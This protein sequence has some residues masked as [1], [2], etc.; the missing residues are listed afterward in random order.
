[1]RAAYKNTQRFALHRV[2]VAFL[3]AGILI[4][5]QNADA[6]GGGNERTFRQPKS[7]VEKTLKGLQSSMGGRLPALEGFALQG[8]HP[9][10]G[11]QR[12]FYQSSVEVTTTA[13][14]GSRVRVNTKVTAWYADSVPSRSGYQLL[15]SNGRLES[16][17]LDELSEAL[18]SSATGTSDG[19]PVIADPSKTRASAN[20]ATRSESAEPGISA[21]MPRSQETARPFSSS[22]SV[23]PGLSSRQLEETKN[24]Q[25]P[26]NKAAT[27]LAAEAASLEEV[28]KN[29]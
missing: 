29:Q 28:L 20:S 23:E 7:V 24:L 6:Q 5:T 9:L 2:L 25:K 3:T 16:D 21:P 4:A 10:S 22:I 13:S 8:E 18:G 1:V 19:F 17:L 26:E 14:G 11:Y 27:G 15:T 12:A